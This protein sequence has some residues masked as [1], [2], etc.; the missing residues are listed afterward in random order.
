MKRVLSNR[1]VVGA[2]IA[3]AA[4][5]GVWVYGEAQY[6]KGFGAA[7]VEAQLATAAIVQGMN[8]EQQRVDARYRGV[9]LARQELEKDH[10][11]MRGRINGLLQEL[12]RARDSNAS[13]G[14]HDPGADWI[15]L[16][17]ACY[18][19]YA[20]LGGDTA[21]LADKLGALQDHIR[22]ISREASRR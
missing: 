22:V 11:A 12:R 2:G 10:V 21:R 17:G 1:Y 6:R 3:L 14:P 5:A 9:V 7:H 4:V 13:G 20:E 15:G 18:A 19:E 8:Y 16:F